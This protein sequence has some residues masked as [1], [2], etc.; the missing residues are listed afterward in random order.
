VLNK[1]PDFKGSAHTFADPPDPRGQDKNQV[2][3]KLLSI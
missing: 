3:I 1:L 2:G